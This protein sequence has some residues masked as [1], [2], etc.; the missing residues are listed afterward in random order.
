MS[1]TTLQPSLRDGSPVARRHAVADGA[2]APCSCSRC[3]SIPSP[4]ASGFPSTPKTGG[5]LANYG[6][7]SP[8]LPRRH[9]ARTFWLAAA[10][11]DA[12]PR[13]RG[14][15]GARVAAAQPPALLTTILVLPITLGTVLIAEGLLT[16]LGPR[17]W[18]NRILLT[19]GLASRPLPL[20][21]NYW[22]V[23]CRCSSPAFLHL[24]ADALLC[25]RDRSGARACGGNARRGP[26][27]AFLA[28]PVPLLRRALPSRFACRS[29]RP[30][31]CFRRRCSW[32]AGGADARD[33][34]RRLSG[35]VRRLRLLDGLGDRD[36]HGPGAARGRRR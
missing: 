20:L 11:D 23:R 36:R 5:A 10:G 35:G 17:G 28:H 15:V 3:S 33:L 4:M 25:H 7:S 16:Y 26:A 30:S 24:P 9:A 13:R 1:A 32:R 14:P 18:F 31:R 29:C 22:G 19:S 21:H 27:A 2:P 12:Q 34:D 6:H 8:I